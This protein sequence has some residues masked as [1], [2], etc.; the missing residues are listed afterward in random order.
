M[1]E[2]A[3]TAFLGAL[4]MLDPTKLVR[5]HIRTGALDD[6][7][8][9]RNNPR[10]IHVIAL[11]KAAP[12][13]VW[14]LMEANVPFAG[15]GV[16]TAGQKKPSLERFWH[17]GGHPMPDA[18][19]YAAGQAV[20]DW[21]DRLPADARVLVLLSGGASA[22]VEVAD[23]RE[24]IAALHQ[25]LGR[26]I[27]ELNAE[28]AAL[29]NFKGGG[30]ATRLQ[31]RGAAV[32]CWVLNDVGP[33]QERIVGSGPCD[34]PQVDHVSLAH[35]QHLAQAAAQYVQALGHPVELRNEVRG[36]VDAAVADF[37]DDW[38]GTTWRVA[39]GEPTVRAPYDAPPGGRT[40]HAALSAARHL[41]P[42]TTFFAAASDGIDGTSGA[43][44]AW[45][46]AGDDGS[47]LESWDAFGWLS[48]RGQTLKLGS[49]GNNLNDLWIAFPNA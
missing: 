36:D 23:D 8:E 41:P 15:I 22:C 29:S 4:E 49:T 25:D 46:H 39:A 33:D 21:V 35:S 20:F 12:R 2:D 11:G 1:L 3:K 13:M 30:L 38:D 17:V 26:P 19:S 32:R 16:T 28:R 44:A 34:L 42:G 45:A 48:A 40:A 24:A 6:W 47:A 18:S 9:D 43:T 27:A 37:L 31:D 14:G 10:P 7:F 5:N